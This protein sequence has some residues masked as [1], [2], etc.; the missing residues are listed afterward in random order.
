MFGIGI[1]ELIVLALVGIIVLGPHRLLQSAEKLGRVVG[2][3]KREWSGW[4]EEP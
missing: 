3:L 2:K 4:G 1:G